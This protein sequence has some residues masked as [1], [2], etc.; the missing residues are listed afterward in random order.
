MDR[1]R[2]DLSNM[3]L[4][5]DVGPVGDVDS[6]ADDVRSIRKDKLNLG[7]VNSLITHSNPN[8]VSAEEETG[9]REFS[10]EI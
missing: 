9:R 8:T 2:E 4:A 6:Q 7:V 10:E 5:L 3:G 1:V